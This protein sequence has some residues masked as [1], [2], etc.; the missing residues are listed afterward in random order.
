MND[1]VAACAALVERADPVRFRA[2]MA[3]PVAARSTLFPLYAFNVEVARAPWVTNEAMI[4]EMRLQWWRDVLEEI[5]S[6]GDVRRHEVATPLAGVLAAEDARRLDELVAV[7]VWDIYS[8]PFPDAQA[9]S[10]YI[11][12][13]TGHLMWTAARI[14]GASDETMVRDYA[15]AAGLASWFLSVPEWLARGHHP[16]PD[17]DPAAIAGLAGAAM[18]RLKTVRSA[19]IQGPARAALLPGAYTRYVLKRAARMPERVLNGTLTPS[20]ARGTAQLMW[21]SA[22]GRL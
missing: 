8:D 21:Q 3:A 14:L 2:A 9:L 16:L 19:A 10:R 7:R 6:G 18:A 20:P 4:A 12:H 13:T 5:A 22:T 1:G 15:A 11:D 17:A